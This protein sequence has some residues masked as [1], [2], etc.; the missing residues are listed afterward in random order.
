MTGLEL[1]R[2]IKNREISVREAALSSLNN[3]KIRDE[4]INAFISV[5]DTDELMKRCDA[6]QR[7]IDSGELINSPLAGVPVAVKDNICT[8]GLRTTCAS[9]MLEDFVP[10]YNAAAVDLLEAAGAIVIGKTNMDEF[11]FGS[12]SETSYFGAVKNP[13][14]P[15]FSPGGS[16]G[17]SAAAVASGEVSIALGTDTGGSVRQPASRCGIVGLK[18]TYGS[19]SRY[20]LIAYASSMDCIGTMAAAV[21]DCA[22]MFDIIA[23]KDERDATCPGYT[24]GEILP[25]LNQGIK[26]LKIGVPEELAGSITEPDIAGIL[27]EG[28]NKLKTAGASTRMIKMESLK[29]SIPVY[30]TIACAEGSSNLERFDG[31]RYGY[32][33]EVVSDL[34]EMY[35]RNRSEGFG[36]EVKRRI[37]LGTYVLSK[38][39]Y[40]EYY[41][42]AEKLRSMI[43][44]GFEETFEKYDLILAPM[45]SSAAPRLGEFD[46]DP[47][48][49]YKT[50]IMSVPA[51]LAGCP[52][53]SVPAGFDSLGMPVGLQLIAPHFREDLL[54]RAAS[55][56]EKG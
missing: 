49:M 7:G 27:N 48:S 5:S 33:A 46:G 41:L 21:S 22:A 51:N 38:G 23:K 32:R 54:L 6:V 44:R 20:G 43:R 36:T 19:V 29:L 28:L 56:L 35:K 31:V 34:R 40:E 1:G 10:P 55:V 13:V 14:D 52:A 12:T 16:S 11:A 47:V 39:F 8:K 15:R 2:K 37:M 24:G 9:K 3:I 30:Y 26:E 42:K 18:P 45:V 50:D 25:G 17:G 53:I 4:E